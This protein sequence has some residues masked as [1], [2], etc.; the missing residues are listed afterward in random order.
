[1]SA[2]NDF[3][4]NVN[5]AAGAVS[6]GATNNLGNAANDVV[7]S[8]GGTLAVTATTTLAAARAF[9]IAGASDI[10]SGTTSTLRGVIANGAST[11]SLVKSGD[12]ALLL[13]AANTYGGSTTVNGA[14]C[15]PASRAS[16]RLAAPCAQLSALLAR[17]EARTFGNT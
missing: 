15:A 17:R 11:G 13:S 14:G 6:I 8:S 2:V 16:R 5:I 7:I 9:S 10:A 12:G 3:T 1:M 4:G